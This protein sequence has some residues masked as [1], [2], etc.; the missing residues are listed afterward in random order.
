MSIKMEPFTSF[1]FCS[2][3]HR[4]KT[5]RLGAT[6]TLCPLL[7]SKSIEHSNLKSTILFSIQSPVPFWRSE[8]IHLFLCNR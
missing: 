1:G 6:L 8:E 7:L 2:A 4:G 3:E 5:G